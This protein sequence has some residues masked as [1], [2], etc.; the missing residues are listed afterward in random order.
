M[1]RFSLV[2][3]SVKRPWAGMAAVALLTLA[4]AAQF[5][6]IR[7]D[8]N[9]KNML[10]ETSEVRLWIGEVEKTFGLYEDMLALGI[11]NENGIVNPGT[12]EKIERITGEILKIKGVSARDVTGLTTI[13]NVTA[14]GETLRVSPLMP[15]LPKTETENENIRKTLFGN[16]LFLDRIISKDGRMTAVYIPLEKGA[17]AKAI[18]DS[19]RAIAAKEQGNEEYYIAGDPV[20]RDTF[21]SEMFKLMGLFSPASGIIMFIVVY[22]MFRSVPLAM[23]MMGAAMISIVW[24]MG[25]LIGLGFPVHIMSSMAPVFLM[26][27]AT[28][29]IH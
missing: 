19:I 7:I 3:F 12:L 8:T 10:P 28:D 18:A 13:D 27:I 15:S 2:E 6:A 29:S 1:R 24:S 9:P 16:P 11:R 14:E 26:A 21:G 25:L 23:C 17:N 20:A 22:I 5:P 4:F